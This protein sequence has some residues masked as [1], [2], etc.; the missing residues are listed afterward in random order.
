MPRVP[1]VKIK[2]PDDE[3]GY[4]IINES[5]YDPEKHDLIGVPDIPPSTKP[6]TIDPDKMLDG[7]EIDLGSMKKNEVIV[8][9]ADKGVQLTPQIKGMK[10]SELKRFAASILFPPEK[11][12]PEE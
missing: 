7:D 10:V 6:I 4:K 9:L 5:E 3:A 8:L 2:W 1:T 12:N 11:D